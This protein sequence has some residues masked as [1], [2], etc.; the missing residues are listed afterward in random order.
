MGRHIKSKRIGYGRNAEN[1]G[2]RDDKYVKCW[3]CGFVCQT[4]RDARAKRG[5]TEG[6]GIEITGAG[7]DTDVTIDAG[8]PMCGCL[9]YKESR[10]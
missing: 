3:N 6:D 5:S 2:Y 9:T 7:E 1:T 8:C 4:Q 10:P